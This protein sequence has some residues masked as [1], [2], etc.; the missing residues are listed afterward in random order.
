MNITQALAKGARNFGA[1]ILQGVKVT[2]VNQANGGLPVLRQ[3][4]GLSMLIMW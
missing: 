4:V 3:I 1:S 2:G